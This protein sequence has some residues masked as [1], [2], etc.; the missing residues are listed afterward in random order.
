MKQE[1][2]VTVLATRSG[3]KR[4]QISEGKGPGSR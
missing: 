2:S 1:M 3:D 4:K